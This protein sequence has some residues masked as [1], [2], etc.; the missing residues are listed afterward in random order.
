MKAHFNKKQKYIRIHPTP[1]VDIKN[2]LRVKLKQSYERAYG[3]L[4]I[5][6]ADVEAGKAIYPVT[7][8]MRG[9][10]IEAQVVK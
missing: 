2:G 5:A 6:V 10:M 3:E 7:K 9:K 4:P 1:K 8:Q